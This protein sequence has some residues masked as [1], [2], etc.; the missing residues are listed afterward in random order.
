MQ[1]NRLLEKAKTSAIHRHLLNYGLRRMIPFNGA[2]HL[3]IEQVMDH[4]LLLTLPAIRQN[5]NHLQG[6]HACALATLCE[7]IS[8]LSLARV[9]PAEE[10]RLILKSIH[11]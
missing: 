3:K 9:L 1:L 4:T 8:G 2:H 6:M 10:Y 5:K 11:V 7:Y